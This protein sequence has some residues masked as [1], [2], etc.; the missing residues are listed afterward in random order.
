MLKQYDYFVKFAAKGQGSHCFSWILSSCFFP[1]GDGALVFRSEVG[2][3][4]ILPR[5]GEPLPA[6]L[7]YRAQTGNVQL[8]APRRM[9]GPRNVRST[10]RFGRNTYDSICYIIYIEAL[11]YEGLEGSVK[12]A[13]REWW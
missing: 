1:W 3:R 4:Q 13:M 11:G 10:T 7:C 6:S 9:F 8:G 5:Q 12:C 2:I